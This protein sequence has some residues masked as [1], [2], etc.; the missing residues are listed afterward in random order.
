[1]KPLLTAEQITE[2]NSRLPYEQGVWFQ[3]NSVPIKY[4][5]HVITMRQET[6][7]YSGGNCWGDSANPY[8]VRDQPQDFL[9]LNEVLKVVVPNITFLQYLDLKKLVQTNEDTY[10]EYYGNSTDY[11]VSYIPLSIL[12]EKLIELNIISD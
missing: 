9:A 6:G 5:E 12:Q 2:I 8:T 3:P 7:G 1:M 4:N 10:Q 11:L